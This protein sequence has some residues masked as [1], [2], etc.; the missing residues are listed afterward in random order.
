[1]THEELYEIDD[2]IAEAINKVCRAAGAENDDPIPRAVRGMFKE[3]G[4]EI[5]PLKPTSE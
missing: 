2:K 4:L 1:M 5:V 3:A